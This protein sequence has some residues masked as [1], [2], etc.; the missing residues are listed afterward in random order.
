[1]NGPTKFANFLY[2]KGDVGNDLEVHILTEDISK[3]KDRLYKCPIGFLKKILPVAP[4]YRM[5]KYYLKSQQL[6]K[7]YNFDYVIYN[8]AIYGLIHAFFKN[9]VVGMIN[10]YNNQKNIS[11]GFISYGFIKKSIFKFFEKK[12]IKYSHLI[13]TNSDFLVKELKNRY[14][15]HSS[16][17]VR[18]YK[19]VE[20]KENLQKNNCNWHVEDLD[21]IK[22]LFVKNDF[23]TG[24]IKVLAESL[25]FINLQ[26]K[27]TIIG[28]DLKYTDEIRSFFKPS[29]VTL[30]LIGRQAP[31][32]VFN[33]MATHHIFC[34]PSLQEALGVA[35]LEAL[36]IGIPVVSS[37]AGGIPEALDH[38]NCG[39]LSRVADAD[40]LST[41]LKNCIY[42]KEERCKKV[43]NGFLQVRKFKSDFMPKNLNRI[44]NEGI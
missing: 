1:M 5:I 37:D 2:E 27:V 35:N 24:G 33:Q 29:N 19:G 36:N 9:N 28:P 10:D 25:T 12:A 11:T 4:I 20:L 3:E 14:P 40:S 44:L 32:E 42:K 18:L 13:L 16:K 30:N 34:V 39:F 17:I 6:S 31:K 38:G 22:I 7:I 21:V 26:F 23:I 43:I 15:R 8:N 41:A